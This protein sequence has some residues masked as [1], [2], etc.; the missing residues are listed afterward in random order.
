MPI[1]G[2][3]GATLAPPLAGS[4]TAVQGD[5]IVRVMMNG[6]TGPIN[7]KTYEAQMVP[8]ATNNDQW[9]ADVTS[10]I[11]KAFGNNGRLVQ[12]KEV[13]KL[14]KELSKRTGPRSEFGGAFA[15]G[16]QHGAFLVFD[17]HRPDGLNRV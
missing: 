4:K 11:R 16:K 3:E 15:V 8:M 12:K 14:R 2:R 1:A 10:Y 9:I 7:G 6:L 17:V 13:E 5:A